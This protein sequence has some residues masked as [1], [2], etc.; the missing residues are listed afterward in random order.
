LRTKDT[1]ERVKK[2]AAVCN[3]YGGRKKAADVIL[4]RA[5]KGRSELN[6]KLEVNKEAM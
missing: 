2:L 3:G 6:G 5:L 1:H 4:E